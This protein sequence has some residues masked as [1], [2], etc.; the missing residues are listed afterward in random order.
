MK[1]YEERKTL[2]AAHHEQGLAN[3]KTNPVPLG[4]K[5]QPG[6]RVRIADDL[7]SS[8]AHFPSGK[9]AT[10]RYTYAHAYGGCD[11]KSYCVDVDNEGAVGWYYESQ[12]EAI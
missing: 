1:S 4:Q 3:V 8:M 2:A 11:V 7:G 10:V 9:L 5:F 12:I 6:Q